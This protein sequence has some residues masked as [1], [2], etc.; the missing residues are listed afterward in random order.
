MFSGKKLNADK[1]ALDTFRC[2]ESQCTYKGENV[3]N[4][5]GNVTPAE[6][7]KEI[8]ETGKK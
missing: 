5:V 6:K 3:L 2:S 4:S 8:S 1:K 7:D